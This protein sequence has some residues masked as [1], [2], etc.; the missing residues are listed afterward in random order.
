MEVTESGKLR[1]LEEKMVA[2][3][4]CVEVDS[5]NVDEV[6]LSLES[7]WIL[8][9]FTGGT[10]TCALAIY[11]LQGLKRAKMYPVENHSSLQT[12]ISKYWS[13][14]RSRF[15]RKTSHVE[16]SNLPSALKADTSVISGSSQELNL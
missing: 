9:V 3:E 8:F 7:F 1:E 2:E 13:L 12:R 4:R 10:S 6:S 14:K 16:M 15:S 11:A 5:R